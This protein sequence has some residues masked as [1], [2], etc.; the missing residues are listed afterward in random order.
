LKA[1]IH[2]ALIKLQ[3]DKERGQ[4]YIGLFALNEGLHSLKYLNDDD[5]QVFQKRYSDKLVNDDQ[6]KQ[7][8]ELNRQSIKEI[9][10][11]TRYFDMVFNQ[12]RLHPNSEWRSKQL[13]KAKEYANRVPNEKSV[14]DLG[15]TGRDCDKTFDSSFV[16]EMV[17]CATA[18]LKR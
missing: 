12:W 10:S 1:K 16:S 15:K 17:T 9:E 14:L 11:L 4:S 6:Q 18:Q 8:D 7:G 13:K 3:A 2:L 5:Y